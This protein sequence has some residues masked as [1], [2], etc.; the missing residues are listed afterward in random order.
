MINVEKS[1][2]FRRAFKRLS[3]RSKVMVEDEIDKIIDGAGK[4]A[5]IFVYA[6]KE[7][8][9]DF[10]PNDVIKFEVV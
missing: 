9:L 6:N 1:P 5:G 8:R 4:R 7:K 10:N 2:V 3:E